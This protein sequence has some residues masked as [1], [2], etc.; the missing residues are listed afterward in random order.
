MNENKSEPVAVAIGI[1]E[2]GVLECNL[3]PGGLEQL[4]STGG[5]AK[6][7]LHPQPADLSEVSGNSGELPPLPEPSEMG[8]YIDSTMRTGTMTGYTREQMQD[9]ARAALAATGKQQVGGVQGSDFD[10]DD[11]REL[12]EKHAK[13]R[14][15]TSDTWGVSSYVDPYVDNDWNEWVAAWKAIASRQPVGAQAV[16]LGRFREAVRYASGV[17]PHED[18]AAKLRELLA[19]IDGRDAG[20]GVG[21]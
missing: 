21:S 12:F 9:Y 2:F 15:L 8:Y 16:D 14:D 20:T 6:L 17:C 19:L 7:Y 18:L 4:Q 5:D 3:L 10:I 11:V 1:S 13:G